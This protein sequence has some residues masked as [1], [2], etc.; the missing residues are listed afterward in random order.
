MRPVIDLIQRLSLLD[1]GQRYPEYSPDD[2]KVHVLY[3]GVHLNATGLYR[4]ILPWLTLNKTQ[5]HCAI[6][7]DIQDWL[8]HDRFGLL[9]IPLT[10]QLIRWADYIVLPTTAH[11]HEKFKELIEYLQKINKTV[12]ICMD[13]DDNYIDIPKTHPHCEKY[14]KLNGTILKNMSICDKITTTHQ[15]LADLYCEQIAAKVKIIS[16]IPTFHPLP[17]LMSPITMPEQIPDPLKNKQFI[18]GITTN[19]TQ[20]HDLL[21]LQKP[22]QKI[23]E[24]YG[25]KVRICLFGHDGRMFN[26][27]FFVNVLAGIKYEYV[28][29][30]TIVNYFT[31]LQNLQYDI[32]LMPLRDNAFNRMKSNHKLLQYA[33]LGISAI[34]PD[35]PPY[36]E[37][38]IPGK[39]QIPYLEANGNWEERIVECV[40]TLNYYEEARKEAKEFVKEHYLIEN[41]INLW[42]KCFN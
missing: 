35:M 2:G 21:L 10:S 32:A 8:E 27:K 19:R 16:T 29:P 40:D 39:P 36:N 11:P 7:N 18:I 37:P 17:N 42:Q 33:Q 23:K 41:N 6:I 9:S 20:T 25:E 15:H 31:A 24:K 4:S 13:V 38:S 3:M 30:V 12:T 34:A 1:P 28:K 26:G 5:T 22:L 14:I